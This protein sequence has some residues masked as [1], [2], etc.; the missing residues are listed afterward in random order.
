MN[1]HAITRTTRRQESRSVKQTC[2][3][4][5]HHQGRPR[6]TITTIPIRR[7][8]GR[9]RHSRHR[10]LIRP[11]RVTPRYLGER[12][13]CSCRAYDRRQGTSTSTFTR[14][15]L[16]S[17]RGINSSRPHQTR[18]HITQDSHTNRSSRGRRPNRRLTRH[19]TNSHISRRNHL[20]TMFNS[21]NI[22]P[23]ST[24]PRHRNSDHPSRNSSTLKS[25]N[26]MGRKPNLALK[27]GATNRRQQLHNIGSQGHTTNSNHGRRQRSQGPHHVNSLIPR[28]NRF[29]GHVFP[30]RGRC[31][32]S[33]RHRRGRHATRGQVSTSSGLVSKRRNHRSVVGRGSTRGSRRRPQRVTRSSSQGHQDISTINSRQDKLQRRRHTRRRRRSSEGSTRRLFSTIT[34]VNTS[35]LQG[36][37]TIVTRKSRTNSGIVNHT[38]RGPTRHGPRGHRKAMNHTRRNTRGQPRANSVRRLSRR[39]LPRQRQGVIRTIRQRNQERKAPYVNPTGALR[40]ASMYGVHHRRRHGTRRGDSRCQIDFTQV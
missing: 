35:H 25:R 20:S 11:H 16:L 6:P 17:T 23:S 4:R 27:T 31:H 32:G 10:H 39:D 18:N 19:I 36:T 37:H 30:T 2:M 33:S 26:T 12:A 7:D 38:R 14:T 40:V 1:H 22:R 9:P 13:R 8:H 21:H 3:N 15:P 34:R 29:K 24:I 5:S 28:E